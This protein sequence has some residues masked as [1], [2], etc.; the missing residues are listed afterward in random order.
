MENSDVKDLPSRIAM[1][2]ELR[3]KTLKL[4]IIQDMIDIKGVLLQYFKIFS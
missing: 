3:G 2:R 1:D 4:P